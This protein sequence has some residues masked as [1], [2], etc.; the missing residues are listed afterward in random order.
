MIKP[1]VVL[2]LYGLKQLGW[3]THLCSSDQVCLNSILRVRKNYVIW[4]SSYVNI[5]SYVKVLL[6]TGSF[7]Y[8]FYIFFKLICSIFIILLYL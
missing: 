7:A 8:H 6:M 1:T 4:E 3:G 2:W 5:F